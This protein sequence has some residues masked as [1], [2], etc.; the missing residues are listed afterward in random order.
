MLITKLHPPLLREQTVRRDRLEAR[1]RAPAGTKLVVLAAPAGYG[2]STLLAS[3]LGS[4][5]VDSPVAWLSVDER[6]NDPAV[7]WSYV[8]EA[9][10]RACPFG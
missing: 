3:W 1:L 2:K 4:D 8:C 7:F 10:R 6:D 5:E 9:L